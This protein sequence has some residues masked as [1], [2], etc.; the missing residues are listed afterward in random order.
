[1]SS[2]QTTSQN[3][4]SASDME[5][6]YKWV[7]SLTNVET[8][9]SALLELWYTLFYLRF[10]NLLHF[11]GIRVV[12]LQRCYRKYAH[13]SNRVCNALALLQCLA[14]H[15]ETRNEFL[16]AN[17]PLYL[18]TFLNTN[19][20]T[21]PFEYLRLT[22]LGVIG[23]LVKVSAYIYISTAYLWNDYSLLTWFRN[24][25]SLFSNYGIRKVATFIMQKLLLDEVGLAY[26]CQ[27]YERFAH[28]ATVLDK[29][30][31]HLARE[32]SL[33]LLKHVIRCYLRLSDDSQNDVATR[34]WLTQLIRQLSVRAVGSTAT[35]S[36]PASSVSSVDVNTLNTTNAIRTALK[37]STISSSVVTTVS[38]VSSSGPSVS[39][40][41]GA[42]SSTSGA[43]VST[44]CPVSSS[45]VLDPAASS[46][47]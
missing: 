9:E 10:L 36:T 24:Y 7:A 39:N 32:Q 19:N 23:A 26:I 11:C 30:V 14:S 46:S 5:S 16:K 43:Q 33:R 3:S 21:R 8:R 41:T 34:R 1:M 12:L 37:T 2:V 47:S 42:P 40:V 44:S 17:I 35:S 28:V 38:T 13:Q 25:T 29:M 31:I 6:V 20:R 15:P 27:T 45:S 22:S 18:Y 4:S